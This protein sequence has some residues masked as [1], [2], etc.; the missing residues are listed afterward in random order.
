LY[1]SVFA[2]IINILLLI[3]IFNRVGFSNSQFITDQQLANYSDIWLDD[4]S[5]IWRGSIAAPDFIITDDGFIS[6]R[7]AALE[8]D[9]RLAYPSLPC[10]N[11]IFNA[12]PED[13]SYHINGSNRVVLPVNGK[14]ERFSDR[15]KPDNTEFEFNDQTVPDI[16]NIY[17]RETV[18]I[19]FLG[20]VNNLPL[21]SVRI[22]PYQLIDNGK[23]LR[24][25][26]EMSVSVSIANNSNLRI[27]PKAAKS[28]LEN[29]LDLNS[30]VRQSLPGKT[31]MKPGSHFL[32]GRK[33]MRIT[34]DSTGIYRI[35]RS[36]LKDS[37]AAISNVDPRSLQLFNRGNEVPIYVK[38]ESDGSFDKSDFIEFY[39]QRNPNSVADYYYDPFTDKNIY[40]LTWG[41]Q[42]G[43]R[44]AE[45]SAKT[46]ISSNNAIVPT[47][48][49]YTAH[50]EE[51]RYFDRLGRVDTD[52]P[53][54]TRDHWFFDSGINGGTTRS[55]TF[56]L[57]YPNM[58]TIER[59]NIE[60]G[61]HGLTYQAGKHTVSV[62]I[63]DYYTATDSWSDQVPH[64]IRNDVGQV[65]QNRYLKHGEN[66][67]QLSVAGDDPT[68]KYDKVLFDYLNIRYKRLYRAHK[69]RIDFARPENKPTGIYHFKIGGFED[70]DISVYKI[71]KSKLMDFSVEY[72]T[73]TDSYSVLIEDYI[74]DDN[75]LYIAA[76]RTGIMQPRSIQ[77]DTIFDIS[78]EGKSIDLLII[79]DQQFKYNLAKLISFY[80]SIGINAHVVGIRDIYNEFNDGIVSPYAIRDYLAY[81]HENWTHKPQAV[82]L[83]G[84]SKIRE[85]E[86]VPAF[87]YQS[88]KYGACPSD[89]WY[90]VLDEKSGIPEY[91]IGRWP[92]SDREELELV[93]DK[94]INYTNETPVGPWHNELLYIAGYEDA[95]KNQ[96]ENM[97]N[98]QIPKEF[99]INRIFIN[100][101]SVKTPFFGGS[102]TLIY[103][104][105][106]GLIL[107]NFMGH[108]GG[109]VWSDRSLF[110]T[111]HIEYLDNYNKL[112]FITSLTCFTADFTNVTGLGEHLLIAENGG[113]IGLWGAT[114]VGWIKNDY[115]MAKPFYDV[116]FNPGMT[117]GEAIRYAK[118]KYLA[119]HYFDY[120]K[121]SMVNSFMLIGDPT[122]EIPF[123][124]K[125][126][127]L[128]ISESNPQPGQTIELSGLTPFTSGEIYTQL[129]DSATYRVY[130]EPQ[131]GQIENGMVRQSIELPL[132]INPGNTFINYY[133]HNAEAIDDGHGV[134]LLNIRGLN[135]YNFNTQPELPEKN[136][137]FIISVRTELANIDSIICELDTVNAYE[138]LDENGIEYV[139]SFNNPASITKQKMVQDIAEPNRWHLQ[140]PLKIGGAG[141]LIGA[142][143]VAYDNSQN[144]TVSNAF[145][146]KIKQNPDLAAIG[147]SQG[148]TTFPELLVEVNYNGDDTLQT[149]MIA[150]KVNDNAESIFN[151]TQIRLLPNRKSTH[152]I[153]GILGT[154]WQQ[155]KIVIDPL[156]KINELNEAN[157]TLTDSL[158]INTF[159]VLPTIGTSLNGINTDTLKF[160]R[161]SI[162]IEP[163]SLMDSSVL[164]INRKFISQNSNQPQFLI[165]NS[166]R[167][168]QLES[169]DISLPNVSDTLLKPLLVEIFSSDTTDHDVFIAHRD[170]Y[171][172]IWVKQATQHRRSS[173]VTE[174]S[175]PGQF[176]L[177]KCLDTE[178]PALELSLDGQQFFQNSFVSRKPNISIIAEDQNGVSF[179]RTG[180]RVFLD[181]NAVSF[182]DLNIPDTLTNSNYVS[183]QFRPELEYGDH[184]I[185]VT[186]KD[187]AGNRT[188]DQIV[189]TVSDELKLIDYGNY[190]NPFKDRTTFIYELTQRVEK[191]KINI[192]APS[193]R[194]IKVL[195]EAT[196]F[197]A[198]LD[199]NEGGYH[200]IMWDGLDKDGNFIANGVYFYKMIAKKQNKKAISIG[201]IAKA[202]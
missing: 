101:S 139:S 190:P 194:L 197:S 85:E 110:N 199:M 181:G 147:I 111:S 175:R 14:P 193:G 51:N 130:P 150:Y 169:I 94:R 196:I 168:G 78:A 57:I 123:P 157:N 119:D 44:Y 162:L 88:Y 202:R 65:L 79:S 100:P 198:G 46:T 76:S 103:L 49:E 30:Q 86:S 116:I 9:S 74:H 149:D 92:V 121:F 42:D 184:D 34:V 72:S 188:A 41:E 127:N 36:A 15:S 192:Y 45:E 201:K 31:L 89:H 95:F 26:E 39:G 178:P 109:A 163:N 167:G 12:M 200:E 195:G 29:A 145:S 132:N 59:F 112:P 77:P 21:T 160:D 54:H 33:L 67:I 102:D 172:R 124:G 69:D 148:G 174:S 24:Y 156:N 68:N 191:F 35:T 17:P 144:Q 97:I 187:A 48:Y 143:F 117:V 90:V 159:P 87:F 164:I 185:E 70:P 22:Y 177:I 73:L 158:Y 126:S 154:G 52:L 165:Q 141:K 6:I 40:F 38:G 7:A 71:G 171:L 25:Y 75:T 125:Q 50:F 61:M 161:Y 107:I 55:Y 105:N 118:I 53:T 182:S 142:R 81:I 23:Q 104:W 64:I 32:F 96:T 66:K 2:L 146:V 13:I 153:P 56:P 1:N 18:I 129:Y 83:I 19:T 63:N 134:T 176:T 180:L 115:L 4:N 5:W 173:Y 140:S 189:F 166:I 62:Y 27:L 8:N 16:G 138:Y 136:Q 91:A 133:F 84:D 93:I 113:A 151:T 37:G 131:I 10:F 135:F 128:T 11:K 99:S 20:Y 179:D 186:I 60:V 58:N 28:N 47:D 170:P 155:F 108:G 3:S 43:L 183:A 122:I 114:S 98:R 80:Q 120:L 82:L 106:K 137:G 152:P